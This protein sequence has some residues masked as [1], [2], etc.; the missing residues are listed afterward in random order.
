MSTDDIDITLQFFS[1]KVNETI[2]KT[3]PTTTIQQDTQTPLPQDILDLIK[4]KNNLRR[5]WQ[6]NQY[7]LF[8][9]QLKSEINGITKIISERIKIQ[10]TTHWENTLKSVKLD[11][12]TFRNIKKFAGTY[13][14]K[15]I[16]PR[17]H[18]QSNHRRR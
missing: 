17:N 6:R 7:S 2:K 15:D 9:H 14:R 16:P 10:N 4:H 3:V 12:H 18:H 13:T 8:D 11:N 1:D 5:R